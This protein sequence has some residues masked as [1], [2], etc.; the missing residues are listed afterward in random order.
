[1]TLR[2]WVFERRPTELRYGSPLRGRLAYLTAF[3]RVLRQMQRKGVATCF[4][5]WPTDRRSKQ[6]DAGSSC[7]RRRIRTARARR[8]AVR[9]AIAKDCAGWCASRS[10]AKTSSHGP[11]LDHAIRHGLPNQVARLE[12]SGRR[13]GD[14]PATWRCRVQP[15]PLARSIAI[16]TRTYHS[17]WGPLR[18]RTLAANPENDALDVVINGTL[19]LSRKIINAAG[20]IGYAATTLTADEWAD[21]CAGRARG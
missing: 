1:M 17:Q 14:D 3:I 18:E 13:R 21:P 7:G 6:W 19:F 20:A 2:A 15:L 4:C 16:A 8:R 11:G 9:V 5:L 12:Q 10:T